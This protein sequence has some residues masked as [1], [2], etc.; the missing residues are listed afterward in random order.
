MPPP[1]R[2]AL[3]RLAQRAYRVLDSF[4][5]PLDRLY[6]RRTRNLRLIPRE[7][8]RKGGKSSYAEWAHVIGTFQTLLYLHLPTM[9]GNEVLDVGCGT[10]IVGIASEPFV[11]RGGKLVG[12]DVQEQTITFCRAHYPT[13]PF[14]FDVHRAHNAVYA[15]SRTPIPQLWDLPKA[16]FDAVTALSVWTHLK[17]ADALFYLDEA[18]RV[19]RPGGKALI[20]L[21]LLDDVYRATLKERGGGLGRFHYTPSRWWIF[22]R[23][24]SNSPGW[25]SPRWARDPELAIGIEEATFR[26]VVEEK[27]FD[28]EAHYQGNWK[29][30]PGPFFQDVVVLVKKLRPEGWPSCTASV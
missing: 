11:Q 8:H 28:V 29:E 27:G 4:Y 7:S 18:A 22:D 17:E 5:V 30:V 15:P 10:G 9:E 12:I 13:P 21:F 19:L 26:R 16:S 6:I 25:F 3:L 24:L 2:R 1:F 20:T 23:P 14:S